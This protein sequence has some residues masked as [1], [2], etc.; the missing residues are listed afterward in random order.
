MRTLNINAI[1][2]DSVCNGEGLRSVIYFQGCKH[3]CKGCHNEDTHEFGTGKD[4]TIQEIIQEVEENS[5]SKKV[6]ISGGDPYFQSNLV[7]LLCEFKKLGYHIVVYTGYE[8]EWVKMH[9]SSTLLYID[10]IVVGKYDETKPD[11]TKT[12]RGSLNQRII[13]LK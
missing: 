4:M 12:H 2:H 10:Q 6:T 11:K 13:N 7:E 1:E 9:K 3:K 8:L 5:L